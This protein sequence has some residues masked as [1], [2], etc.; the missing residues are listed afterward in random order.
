V[1]HLNEEDLWLFSHCFAVA[2]VQRGCEIGNIQLLTVR[3]ANIVLSSVR[4]N[5]DNNRIGRFQFGLPGEFDQPPTVF[6]AGKCKPINPPA[7]L[8]TDLLWQEKNS[9]IS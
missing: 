6:P 7:Q 5:N 8:T 4:Q 1:L 2:G 9:Q 3:P